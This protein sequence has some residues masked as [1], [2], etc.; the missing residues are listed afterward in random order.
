MKKQD[1]NRILGRR[2]AT[3]MSREELEKLAGAEAE[4]AAAS[5]WTLSYPP[6]GPYR[7]S[8]GGGG[9]VLA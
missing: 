4:S 6:D 7:D 3:E 9:T 8:G 5:T 2:L 1:K